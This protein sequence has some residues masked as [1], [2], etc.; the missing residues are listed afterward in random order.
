MNNYREE[1]G[2]ISDITNALKLSLGLKLVWPQSQTGLD[3][4]PNSVSDPSQIQAK[5]YGKFQRQRL[6]HHLSIQMW[7]A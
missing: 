4:R 5:L 3:L 6:R 7:L 2:V 1:E